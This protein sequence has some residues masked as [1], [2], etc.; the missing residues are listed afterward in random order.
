MSRPWAQNGATLALY[1]VIVCAWTWP[2][3]TDPTGL[4]VSPQFDAYSLIWLLDEAPRLGWDMVSHGSAW[5]T[6][7]GLVR[8]DSFI[9]FAAAT[10]LRGVVNP[11]LLASSMALLGPVLSAWAAERFAAHSLRV[12]WPWSL[13]A[14]L[15]Y[16]FSGLMATALL[17]GHYYAM[18]TPWLPLL[19]MATL[20]ATGPRARP[21]HGVAVAVMW[22]LCLLTTAYCGLAASLLVLGLGA[23]SPRRLLRPPVLLACGLMLA[24][25]AGFTWLYLRGD[26]GSGDTLSSAVTTSRILEAGSASVADLALVSPD[27]ELIGH[28]ISPVLGWT[29]LLL[30]LTAPLV[31]KRLPHV[32]RLMLLAVVVLTI[33]MGPVVEIAGQRL[34]WVLTPLTH[35]DWASAFRFPVRLMPVA[36]LCMGA[37]AA[38]VAARLAARSPRLAGPLLLFAVVDCF[39]GI[40]LPARTA[41]L[42]LDVPSAYRGLPPEGGLLELL[43]YFTSSDVDDALFMRNLACSYQRV[44]HKPLTHACLG[45]RVNDTPGRALNDYVLEGCLEDSDG[46][47]AQL[48]QWL[49]ALGVSHVTLRPLLFPPNDREPLRGCLSELAGEPH[50]T[51]S[52]GGELLVIY[53]LIEPQDWDPSGEH[54]LHHA[55]FMEF[56]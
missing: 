52:D 54:A 35:M 6:G 8:V 32:R 43:P 21:I 33:T 9:A 45:T 49:V 44:H 2:L 3:V 11:V 39:L 51:S 5:P 23:R 16:G 55:A 50:A 37:I 38:A 34:P 20:L 17:E 1:A 25:G 47:R 15:C 4:S 7:H 24:T 30:F 56:L 13:I 27:A 31:W 40:G 41:R 12:A 18:V 26:G 22:T 29:C 42:P 48:R 28:S 10:A 53:Q 19:A 46:Q 36:Y 14:G